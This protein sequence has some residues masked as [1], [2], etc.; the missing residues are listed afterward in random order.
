MRKIIDAVNEIKGEM[1]QTRQ[2]NDE[3]FVLYQH[4]YNPEFH[5]ELPGSLHI[6]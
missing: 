1:V 5:D 2:F 4:T 6:G 3:M